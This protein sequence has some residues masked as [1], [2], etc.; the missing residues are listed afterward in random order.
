MKADMKGLNQLEAAT[1][2]EELNVING[3]MN[4]GDPGERIRAKKLF[5]EHY[6]PLLLQHINLESIK[7]AQQELGISDEEMGFPETREIC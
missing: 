5:E 4:H 2:L 1:L 3:M 6:E 7:L